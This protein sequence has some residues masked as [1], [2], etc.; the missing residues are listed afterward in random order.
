[1]VRN[2]IFIYLIQL[3]QKIITSDKIALVPASEHPNTGIRI[4]VLIMSA[5]YKKVLKLLEKWPIDQT[6][7]TRYVDR[8]LSEKY[9]HV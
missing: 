8:H 5:S 9:P 1:M 7:P 3:I 2:R 6:K 4:K